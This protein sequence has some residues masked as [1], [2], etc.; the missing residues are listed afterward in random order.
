[1][2]RVPWSRRRRR[3]ARTAAVGLAGLGIGA[4]LGG[5]TTGR[6]ST[7]GPS[8]PAASNDLTG[9]IVVIGTGGLSWSDVSAQGTPALWSLLQDGA[10]A[11]LTI[12]AVHANTCPVDGWL[13]LSAGE[14]AADFDAPSAGIDSTGHTK[15][16]SSRA[17]GSRT[18]NG[19][20]RPRPPAGGEVRPGA[21]GWISPCRGWGRVCG[22]RVTRS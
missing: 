3:A 9:S 20:E 11:A 13:T 6:A 16:S 14:Q 7:G 1:M 2:S 22:V 4:L 8:D 12:H 18:S 19:P 21:R 17:S 5:S 15:L 10:T